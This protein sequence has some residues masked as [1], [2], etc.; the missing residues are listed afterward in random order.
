[1]T[2]GFTVVMLLFVAIYW[3]G[4]ASFVRAYAGLRASAAAEQLQTA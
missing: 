4:V 2:Y 3:L 1:M